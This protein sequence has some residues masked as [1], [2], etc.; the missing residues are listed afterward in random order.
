VIVITLLALVTRLAWNLKIHP[1]HEYVF[2]DMWGY[3]SR[4]DDFTKTPLTAPSDY[5]SFFPWGTHALLGVVKK[6]FTTPTTCPRDT[7][8]SIASAGCWPMDLA[9]ALLG[10]F[11]VVYTTLLARRMTQHGPENA[12]DGPRRRVWIP[13]SLFLVF[14][15]PILAQG[16]YFMSEIPF[17]AFFSAATY[18]SVRLV[19]RGKVSD[20][21]LF[22]LYAGLATWMRPQ[23]LMSVGF[24]GIFWLFRRRQLPGATFKRL[25]LAG[26]PLLALLAFSAVRTTRHIRQHD[27][28]EFAL[29]ST[30]DA[31]NYTF[32]RCHPIAIEAHTK[33]YGSFFGPPSLGSLYF[34]ARDL[35]K[36]GRPVPL[37]LAPA[38]PP[39]PKCDSNKKHLSKKE[40][41]EP[42]LAIEGKM[43]S[44]DV[45]GELATKCV[46]TAGYGRQAYYAF[47]HAVLNVGFNIAWPDS[48]QP[49]REV[50]LW[51]MTFSKG[52]P[53][54]E[55]WQVGFGT[56]ILPLSMI[57]II[58]AFTKRRARDGLLAMHFWAVTLVGM[59][60]FGD[61]RLRTPYD[62]LFII[63]GL[64]LA[65]RT[66][67]RVKHHVTGWVA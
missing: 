46:Q 29:V 45:L 61:T 28:K 22:G 26:V 23:M 60:Y 58:L 24:L 49:Y 13:M 6:L 16:G 40:E 54:M 25:A 37:E 47:T 31:L 27:P 17:F 57:A 19:D 4:A 51:G 38:L 42:C 2:S 36:Q 65:A 59:L 34:T 35:R 5:M 18:H 3:F 55:K 7:P 14:Y 11:G 39:D 53:V 43:W 50:K 64:D 63:L 33:N 44:R 67:S 41:L 10:A 1:P 52:R 21:L 12:P 62:G 56:T 15:Y 66:L 48:G 30:N 20:A 9:M 32:G 8:N